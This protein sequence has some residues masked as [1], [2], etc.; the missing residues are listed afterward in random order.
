M[1]KILKIQPILLL[2][3]SIVFILL[4]AGTASAAFWRFGYFNT[5]GG[6]VPANAWLDTKG[7]CIA[8]TQGNCMTDTR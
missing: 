8:G 1:K 2:I 5:G 4:L 3:P 7:A 6:G